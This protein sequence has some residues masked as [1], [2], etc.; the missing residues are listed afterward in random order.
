MVKKRQRKVL[1]TLLTIFILLVGVKATVIAA[2][3]SE[4]LKAL[5]LT[6][7]DYTSQEVNEL[8]SNLNDTEVRQILKQELT[9]EATAAEDI[10]LSGEIP[11]PGSFLSSA[12][13]FLTAFSSESGDRFKH[14]LS[15]FTIILPDLYKV[16]LTL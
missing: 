13:T 10:S 4:T 9:Q 14:L 7:D 5:P 1:A 8:L 3:P 15:G 6:Q 12:L 16:F 11:G 2:D